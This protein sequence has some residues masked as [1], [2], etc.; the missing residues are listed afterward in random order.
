VRTK[1]Q[2]TDDGP[3][4]TVSIEDNGAGIE[5]SDMGSI[6]E[7]FFTTK[8]LGT[9][10]GLTNARKVIELHGG[11]IEVASVARQGTTITMTLPYESPA[12]RAEEP[13]LAIGEA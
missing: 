12:P 5:E 3:V 2:E 4:A 1:Q 10:L 11:R 9:G 8:S 7:A 6:F 13:E